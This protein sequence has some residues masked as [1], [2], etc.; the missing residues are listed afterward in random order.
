MIEIVWPNK[1]LSNTSSRGFRSD[2]ASPMGSFITHNLS[3]AVSFL[4]TGN[5]Y[6]DF[7]G[8]QLL[9][10]SWRKLLETFEGCEDE[11]SLDGRLNLPYTF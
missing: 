1:Y 7:A 8:D 6:L 9:N 5:L 11:P 4:N 2:T 3:T 10:I